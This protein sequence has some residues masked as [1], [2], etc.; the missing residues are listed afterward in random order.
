MEVKRKVVLIT[1]AHGLL[2]SEVSKF[3]PGALRPTHQELDVTDRKAVEDF[4]SKNKPDMVVHLAAAVSP[5][6]CEANKQW[7]WDTSVGATEHMVDACE[8]HVPGCYFVLMSTPCVFNGEDEAPKDED[9]YME[10][11]SF[12]GY[13]KSVQEV[14]VERSKLKSLIIRGNFVGYKKWPY[15]KAFTDRKSNYLFS[16]QLAR[17]ISE[18]IAAE[19]TGRVHVLG[20]KVLSMFE[21]ARK[22][23]DSQ[24][25]QPTTLDEY[26][27]QNPKSCKLTKSMVMKSTKWK[28]YPIDEKI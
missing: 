7:A 11:D 5:V 12:Y 8:V 9:H 17:G 25:V 13:T 14:V 19:M 1:G 27:K 16:H 2:G 24:D 3:F 10:P 20:D 15:P 28:T 6:K 22:C 18:V 21:L 26:Y 23:P 4:I